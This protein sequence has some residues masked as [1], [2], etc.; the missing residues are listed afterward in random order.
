M[1]FKDCLGSIKKAAG[2]VLS[3]DEVLEVLEEFDALSRAVAEERP[4]SSVQAE[5]FNHAQRLA[6]EAR[7]VELIKRRND[8]INKRIAAENT[9]FLKR[10]AGGDPYR[11]LIA[12][13]VGLLGFEQGGKLSV[14][15]KSTALARRW[16]GS[17]INALEKHDL[18]DLMRR[19]AADLPIARELW[20]L[21]REGGRPGVSGS[22]E[23]L[24]AARVIHRLQEVM[25]GRL[26]RSGAFIKRLGGYIVRQSHDPG[27]IRREGF[28]AWYAETW[29]RVDEERTFGVPLSDDIRRDLYQKLYL[30]LAS[31]RHLKPETDEDLLTAASF[32]GGMNLAKKRSAHRTIHFRSADD[33]WAYNARFGGGSMMELLQGSIVGNARDTALLETW[34]TNPEAMHRVF[35]EEIDEA[36]KVAGKAQSD[37][38]KVLPPQIM[39]DVVSGAANRPASAALARWMVLAR[40]TQVWSK[41]GSVVISALGDAPIMSGELKRHGVPFLQRVTAPLTNLLERAVDQGERARLANMLMAY[42][43]GV[44]SDVFGRFDMGDGRR[45]PGVVAWM[46]R[47]FWKATGAQFWTDSHRSGTAR[48]IAVQMADHLSR[49]YAQAPESYRRLLGAYG[50]GEPDWPALKAAVEEV[51]GLRFVLPQKLGIDGEDAAA[52]RAARR[53]RDDLAARLETFLSDRMDAAVLQPGARTQAILLRG[54][55]PGTPEGELFRAV[56]QFKSF[57]A[58]V[59][60]R[61]WG[62]RIMQSEYAGLAAIVLAMT[63]M[64][65]VSTLVSDTLKGIAPP[66]FTDPEQAG[67]FVLRSFLRGGGAGILGDFVLGEHDRYGRTMV[68][69]QAGPLLSQFDSAASLYAA[70]IRGEDVAAKAFRMIYTNLPFVNLFYARTALDYLIVY[71]MQEYLNPGYLRRMERRKEKE[72]GQKYM[73][74]PS[75][76]AG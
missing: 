37:E 51:E 13:D 23:A 30:D 25:V 61:V 52:R 49:P 48:M 45:L 21:N 5:L 63:A 8:A 75:E 50:I 2:G 60:G 59:L 9:A 58:E 14:G 53:E 15:A 41:L 24:Q 36:L 33:W 64:G 54:S 1:S 10:F 22:K 65:G 62:E 47:A 32:R 43:D 56:A 55:R 20:E 16:M 67:Q 72:T 46:N 38:R 27:R 28:Q 18:L 57:P 11:A 73:L 69:Q 17:L 19:G 40:A 42:S 26:N 44:S 34:G 31:G 66:D 39:F 35:V 70:L 71:Q 76:V 3:D 74:A 12:R 4:W 6:K 29:P 68:A 7:E